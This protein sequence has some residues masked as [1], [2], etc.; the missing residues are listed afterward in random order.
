MVW[1]QGQVHESGAGSLRI[2]HLEQVPGKTLCDK[3]TIPMKAAPN[4][5]WRHVLNPCPECRQRAD[6]FELHQDLAS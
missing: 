3:S 4:A 1:V 2:W 6:G 5:E